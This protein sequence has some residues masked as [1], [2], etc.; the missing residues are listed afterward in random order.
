MKK[1]L[2]MILLV[3][4]IS[5]YA[6][7]N[8]N[9]LISIPKNSYDLNSDKVDVYFI[10]QYEI[11]AV[12]SLSVLEELRISD[13]HILDEYEPSNSYYILENRLGVSESISWGE[14]VFRSADNTIVKSD[15]NVRQERVFVPKL[16]KIKILK[17]E[18]MI[19]P[20]NS[21]HSRDYIDD[22]IAEIEPDSIESVIQRLEDFETRFA[23]ADNR[24]E[25]VQWIFDKF[26][27]Y[28]Y[29]EVFQDSF[30]LN[31]TI[32]RNVIAVLPGTLNTDQ[33]VVFG[34]HH[35][36]ICSGSPM[37]YAPG[38]DDNA[39]ATSN[40]LE[41]ARV[42]MD[43]NYQPD[44]NIVFITF[45]AEELGLV[46][47]YNI[48][49]YMNYLDYDVKLMLNNDM[50]AHNTMQPG[51]WNVRIYA[52]TGSEHYAAFGAALAEVY[53]NL[54]Y[55]FTLHNSSGSDSF[56]FWVNGFPVT[57]YEE[58]E[59]SP[60]WHTPYDIIE[61]CDIDFCTEIAK[62]DLATILSVDAMPNTVENFMIYDMGDGT[63]L[64]LNWSASSDPDFDHYEYGVGIESGVYTEIFIT[65]DTTNVV[66]G[67]TEGQEYFIA[68]AAVDTDGNYSFGVERSAIPLNI[69]RAPQ[70]L[71]ALP[72]YNA[73]R[74]FWSA[75]IELDL[76]G[77][78]V[79]RSE[80]E[81]GT[82]TLLNSILITEIYY[83]DINVISGQYYFYTITAVD[84]DGNESDQSEMISSRSI[85]LDSGILLVD[86]TSDGNGSYGNPLEVECDLFYQN[87]LSSFSFDEL[88]LNEESDLITE[89]LG[90][91]STVIWHMNS[92]L[93]SC[94]IS[95]RTNEI[96]Q[97]LDFGGQLIVTA[98]KPSQI[99]SFS[100][101]Y[102]AYFGIGD[103]FNDY[104]KVQT[105]DHDNFARFYYADPETNFQQVS[106]D[107]TKTPAG[108]EYHINKVE[109]IQPSNEG[110]ILYSYGSNYAN[111]NPYGVMNGDPVCV[112]YFGDYFKTA[113]FSFPFYYMNE[114]EIENLLF[115]LL[116]NYF[117]EEL[118]GH[119]QN[120]VIPVST[121]LYQNYPNPFN[122]TTTI[123]FS[124]TAKDAEDA[125]LEIYNIK[126]QK[127]ETLVN[128]VLS[129]GEHS[130]I[131]NGRDSN[132]KRV[133]SGIYLYKLKAGD[134]TDIKKM[135]LIK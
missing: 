96:S 106:V 89:E 87:V 80:T 58:L 5:M 2:V 37:T 123:S 33:Y 26:I 77:Y 134:Y 16:K 63:S 114:D 50:V 129:V 81:N 11:I 121:V 21:S 113:L 108:L 84:L 20:E 25:V 53:T 22:L 3:I 32:Q 82:Q 62:L 56:A 104:F 44:V 122:P 128:E 98:F 35:D 24:D 88:E 125:Q 111:T 54:S 90:T 91:Y 34:G 69:P 135:I 7:I 127:V 75:N 116:T 115:I 19:I 105:I 28:G 107:T 49:G 9:Y 71:D 40:V 12:T 95:D 29:A 78:N 23:Y 97:Y 68:V 109:S 66:D 73:V 117:D 72:E 103:F 17:M 47:A 83:L 93:P 119:E 43:Q 99:F 31:G 10:D 100:N 70:D 39:S 30:E 55:T 61:N 15:A 120:E 27:S 110:E 102:P 74:L 112:G 64:Q 67:L 60:Y 76:A 4:C 41:I 38:A 101:Y 42:L 85:T 57:Y 36:S 51:D 14:I 131:W 52:Y 13:Y 18:K 130:I 126:G 1:T 59:F 8:Q 46:G 94:D 79:Y 118:A 124:L 86:N 48:A 45:A 132:N 65:S 92:H 133:S 6:E